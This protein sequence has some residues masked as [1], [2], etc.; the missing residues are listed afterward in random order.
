MGKGIERLLSVPS[1]IALRIMHP[2]IIVSTPGW[3]GPER[4]K[5]PRES[6]S[7]ILDEAGR[8]IVRALF[9]DGV[10]IT[11]LDSLGMPGSDDMFDEARDLSA[12]LQ[13]R[14]MTPKLFGKSILA[15]EADDLL[16]RRRLFDW[17]LNGRILDIAEAYLRTTCAYDGVDFHYSVADGR[18]TST[19]YWH[20]DR[21]DIRQLKVIV[22]VNDVGDADGP[23]EILDPEF[24][25]FLETSLSWRYASVADSDIRSLARRHCAANVI[26]SC[27]GAR[28][29][30]IFVDTARCH[31]HGKPPTRRDRSAVF[32][33]Y[34][35]RSPA[36][37]FCCE[38]SPFSR[39]QLAE[40]ARTLPDRERACVLWRDSLSIP[41]RL[42]PRN[43]LTV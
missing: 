37:P 13:M 15:A 38:R 22:Y 39:A 5:A 4:R 43:R 18:E 20:R 42:I 32:F 16:A 30:V 7:V 23:F 28:G 41:I 2:P 9:K 35:S 25:P 29:T 21:E 1:E 24:Q 34:F 36:H 12:V 33:S 3:T 27:T 31:H 40:I 8:T 26:R 17:G 11:S 6:S 10:H 14:S 19:R